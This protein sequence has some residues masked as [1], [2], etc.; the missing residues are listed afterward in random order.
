MLLPTDA[1]WRPD[2]WGMSATESPGSGGVQWLVDA[3]GCGESFL[4]SRDTLE[5]LFERLVTE[6]DLHPAA[7]AQWKVFPGEGGVTGL[8]LLS[9]SHL[10]C[11]T[12]P[13][14]GIATFDLYCCRAR[15][16]WPWGDRLAE[17]IGAR[18]VDVRSVV[19]GER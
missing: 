12:Y 4:R 11:H 8:L 10:A 15:P 7:E 16:E 13:E 17:S 18:R 9:E 1:L 19:R 5:R 14:T 2:G 3:H 6:L